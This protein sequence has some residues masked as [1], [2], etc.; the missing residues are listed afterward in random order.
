[1]EF[2]REI[3][4]YL[5]H[6]TGES[7]RVA[8]LSD[9]ALANL[10]LYLS[11]AYDL[12][13]ISFF[14]HVM[15]V[16]YPRSKI[17]ASLSQLT[18]DRISLTSKLGKEV[19]LALPELVSYERRDLIRKR[20]PFI[21]PGKQLFLPMWLVDL[22]EAYGERPQPQGSAMSWVSQTVILKH[23]LE[24]GISGRPLADISCRLGYSAMAVSQ[25]VK[26]LEALELCAK[27]RKGRAKT[28]RFD[29]TSRALWDRALRYMRSPVR[30]RYFVV[31]ADAGFPKAFAAGLSALSCKTDL[32]Y[33]SQEVVAMFN[34]D[35]RRMLLNNLFIA[36]AYEED[37][38]IAVEG[39]AYRPEQ[40]S[41]GPEVDV[42]SLY[43]SLKDSLDERVQKALT[44]IMERREW[45][46]D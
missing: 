34:R 25:S 9:Q 21:V 28:I 14:G 39:W 3:A 43:L 17:R 37:A 31:K 45:S 18:K 1:M 32:A 30:K 15:P 8:K 40:L 26:E 41:D 42:F 27:I 12:W 44:K 29:V 5:E 23:L 10:P 11:S 16:A 4:L 2:Y 36:G 35:I 33:S 20:V 7:P 6:V 24:G 19:V 13:E 46:R 22:R 38:A